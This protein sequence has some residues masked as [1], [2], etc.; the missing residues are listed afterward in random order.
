VRRDQAQL[1]NGRRLERARVN[2]AAAENIR[3][4]D[5][6]PMR[7]VLLID[8]L[9]SGGA[10]R[11]LCLLA[12]LLKK[13]GMDVSVLTYHPH[14]FFLPLLR[15]AGIE[16]ACLEARSIGHRILRL[17]RALR[18]GSQDVVLAFLEGASLYAEL[19]A[20]PRRSWGLVVSER[21]AFRGSDVQ[22]RFR[23]L[24][25]CHRIAD[26][27]TTNSHA[28]RLMIERSAPALAGRVVTVYNA[29]DLE[30]FSPAASANPVRPGP[31]RIVVA[32]TFRSI[33]NPLGFIEALMIANARSKSLRFQLDW[34][35][36]LPGATDARA[37]RDAYE[38]A[39]GI[40]QRHCLQD[41]VRFHPPTA[42]IGDVFRGADV[43]ALPSLFE[44]LPNVVCE[45]MACG[46]PI[47]MS[48]VSDAGNLVKHG[49]NGFLFDPSSSQDMAGAMLQFAALSA[50]QREIMG[51]RSREMAE[52]MF[53][54][55]TVAARYAEILSLA[56]ARK[57]VSVE[58]WIP[59]VPESAYRSSGSTRPTAT[60][61]DKDEK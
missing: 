38:S 57:R 20:I 15:T 52:R 36:R 51:R 48:D 40:I 5:R 19:A 56:A 28:N 31:L 45:A 7:V 34:Y 55:A 17:R 50:Q 23:W 32:A 47:L 13:Q 14:E 33:K 42:S 24:R 39:C 44:G 37:D 2:A 35:G 46:R 60:P 43:V 11:Q 8:C 58:H 9:G 12:V 53:D 1:G 25:N 30:A 49:H 16:Y 26:Y 27:V 21:A 18:R 22:T 4:T 10:Q 54:P 61:A 3:Q 41:C 59:D 29:T 6:R